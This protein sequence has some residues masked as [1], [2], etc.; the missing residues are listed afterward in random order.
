MHPPSLGNAARHHS[1]RNGRIEAEAAA[2]E[3]ESA[4]G[5][6]S[7]S[8]LGNRYRKPCGMTLSQSSPGHENEERC[9]RA[10]NKISGAAGFLRVLGWM[11]VFGRVFE[12]AGRWVGRR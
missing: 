7:R 6:A 3:S 8:S 4:D 12:R 10:N 5:S 11:Q 2:G 9:E 1:G